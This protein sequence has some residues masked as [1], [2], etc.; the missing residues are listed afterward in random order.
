VYIFILNVDLYYCIQILN[1]YTFPITIVIVIIVIFF[2]FVIIGIGV[3][4]FILTIVIPYTVTTT[5]TDISSRPFIKSTL[6]IGNPRLPGF[7]ARL[8]LGTKTF[9]F[10]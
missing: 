3:T 7:S 4:L 5:L 8:A 1:C 2:F 10:T 6:A 9:A